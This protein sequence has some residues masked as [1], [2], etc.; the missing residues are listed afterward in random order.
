[1][2]SIC[3]ANIII[4]K[5]NKKKYRCILNNCN[6]KENI[7]LSTYMKSIIHEENYKKIIDTHESQLIVNNNNKILLQ[8]IPDDI[9]LEMQILANSNNTQILSTISHKI[10]IP[11]TNIFGMLSLMDMTKTNK[12]HKKN[13]GLLKNSCYEIIAVVN[14]IIDIVNA[15]RG[16]LKLNSQEINLHNLLMEC[17]EIIQKDLI[18]KNLNLKITVNKNL[19]KNIIIDATKLKQVIINMLNNSIHN[20]DIGGIEI[21]VSL[22]KDKDNIN[23]PFDFID[24]KKPKYNILFMIKDTG[25]GIDPK[26]QDYLENVLGISKNI[27]TYMYGGLGLI[28]SKYLCQLMNGNIWFKSEPN[29]GTIFYFNIVCEGR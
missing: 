4:W 10:R 26:I 18:N 5:K 3:D 23:Y 19:C 2:I 17:H 8:Y 22:F 25:C 20:T 15:S 21:N 29:I 28:V 16:E 9:I 12:H 7:K 11:L 13:I 6:L 27:N 14:D 24:T 1:M